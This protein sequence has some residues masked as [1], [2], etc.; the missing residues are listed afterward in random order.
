MSKKLTLDIIKSRA[1]EK[2]VELIK[3]LNLWGLKL[4]DIS[5]LSELPLLETISL[6]KNEI[7][8]ISVFKTMKN[9]KELYLADNQIDDLNQ[10]EY[11]KNC[12]KL[13][14]L[15]LK[16]N[17]ICNNSNYT[18]KIIENISNLLILDEKDI[19]LL[20]KENIENQNIKSNN[21]KINGSKQIYKNKNLKLTEIK[22][23]G[24]ENLAAPDPGVVNPSPAKNDEKENGNQNINNNLG[25]IDPV[26][27][28]P[29]VSA[30][31][32]EIF[33]KSF[34][35]KKTEGTFFKLRK[36]NKNLK[37]NLNRNMNMNDLSINENNN[38]LNTSRIEEDDRFKTLPTSLS[39]K[40]FPMIQI[41]ILKEMDIKEK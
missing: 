39:L 32:L 33:N 26:I 8:D 14:K 4:S 2:S 23:D 17:P 37:E 3:T 40:I 13:E 10:I 6:S 19:K 22:K 16:G 35:K 21:K 36:S 5:I 1:K 24:R 12:K 38:A 18:Q 7:K 30:K 41:Q 34:K 25:I 27:G 15:V 31:T 29:K 20:K 11:L 28:N 9:I